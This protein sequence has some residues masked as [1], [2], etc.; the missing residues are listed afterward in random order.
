[1]KQIGV[2][3]LVVIILCGISS[4]HKRVNGKGKKSIYAKSI[5]ADTSYYNFGKIC[6]SDN[7]ITHKFVLKNGYKRPILITNI[8]KGC[9]CISVD[10]SPKYVKPNAFFNVIVT[11]NPENYNGFFRKNIMVLFNDGDL[12]IILSI[13]GMVEECK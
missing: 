12:F 6:E 10:C 4:C 1:M 9:H 13:G 8:V 7:S 11:F 2:L 5:E 3:S